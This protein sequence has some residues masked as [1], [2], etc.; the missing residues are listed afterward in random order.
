MADVDYIPH[1]Q[2]IKAEDL[3]ALVD[4]YNDKLKTLYSNLP[5][6]LIAQDVPT[7]MCFK[8]FFFC[9]DVNP[10]DDTIGNVALAAYPD[11]DTSGGVT[12]Y[13]KRAYIDS[14]FLSFAATSV[15]DDGD[16]DYEDV[17]APV[18]RV[19][20]YDSTDW[21]TAKAAIWPDNPSNAEAAYNIL[22]YSLTPHQKSGGDYDGDYLY[23]KGCA[24]SEYAHYWE[25]VEIILGSGTAS[26]FEWSIGFTKYRLFRFSNIT[27]EDIVV[28]FPV[29]DEEGDFVE[30]DEVTVYAMTS[31]CVRRVDT[32]P[33]QNWITGYEYFQLPL[34]DDPWF[35]NDQLNNALASPSQLPVGLYDGQV[36][37]AQSG[38]SPDNPFMRFSASGLWDLT[39][40]YCGTPT[41]SAGGSKHFPTPAGGW[42]YALD[43]ESSLMDYVLHKGKCLAVNVAGPFLVKRVPAQSATVTATNPTTITLTKFDDSIAL[44]VTSFTVTRDSDSTSI[45]ADSSGDVNWVLTN[46]DPSGPDDHWEVAFST[47]VGGNSPRLTAGDVLS[48]N[49]KHL[50]DDQKWLFDFK[51][52]DTLVEQMDTVGIT[53]TDPDPDHALQ[54]SL[55]SGDDLDLIGL[56]TNF[57][58]GSFG[59]AAVS[60]F[61]DADCSLPFINQLGIGIGIVNED[62]NP[63][64]SQYKTYTWSD[65]A[66]WTT[67]VFNADVG[68]SVDSTTYVY[69]SNTGF[70]FSLSD[71]V[72]DVFD[73]VDAYD[74]GVNSVGSSFRFTVFGA[75]FHWTSS[76][77]LTYPFAGASGKFFTTH[78]STIVGDGDTTPYSIGFENDD[79][80]GEKLSPSVPLQW[81]QP[82]TPISQ[83]PR[84]RR[85]SSNIRTHE[86]AVNVMQQ[87]QPTVQRPNVQAYYEPEVWQDGQTLKENGS[88]N[89][90]G[91]MVAKSIAQ[92]GAWVYTTLSAVWLRLSAWVNFSLI[93][94]M[95][96]DGTTGTDDFTAGSSEQSGYYGAERSFL[97]AGVNGGTSDAALGWNSIPFD[98]EQYNTLASIVNGLQYKNGGDYRSDAQYLFLEFNVVSGHL[99]RGLGTNGYR[100]RTQWISWDDS[101][102]FD[103]GGAGSFTTHMTGL[104]FTVLDSSDFPAPWNDFVTD[105]ITWYNP[106]TVTTDY[107]T[108]TTPIS[109]LWFPYHG[110]STEDVRTDAGHGYRWIAID[111]A[112]DVFDIYGARF[113]M[114]E[115]S[116]PATLEV[117]VGTPSLILAGDGLHTIPSTGGPCVL[118]VAHWW[119]DEEGDWV[120]TPENDVIRDDINPTDLSV[121]AASQDGPGSVNYGIYSIG[122]PDYLRS[123]LYFVSGMPVN[124][125]AAEVYNSV[126]LYRRFGCQGAKAIV[127][128]RN[129]NAYDVDYSSDGANALSRLKLST[130]LFQYNHL[131]EVDSLEG[132]SP[133]VTTLS[134]DENIIT[135]QIVNGQLY[136]FTTGTPL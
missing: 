108:G 91:Q 78:D 19:L 123:R 40:Y 130:G 48:L 2:E 99:S 89:A 3:A 117:N 57:V 56:S 12:R 26:P 101:E 6:F 18:V 92:V 84:V 29:A 34:P 76:V 75:A 86:A 116:C 114:Q 93:T 5:I 4:G 73:A 13:W 104:G 23:V 50:T 135:T 126:F 65:H 20:P 16:P 77:P 45:P 131:T 54:I 37:S 15:V 27:T 95:K 43:D 55:S 105:D 8:K 109:D 69:S 96:S 70:D 100:P 22:E 129:Y 74:F 38:G 1:G 42:F 120:Y 62:T 7:L 103:G 128:P 85:L 98:V 28:R 112:R 53:V 83:Y 47:R 41:V 36:S 115:L 59:T 64:D 14:A 21:A 111:D 134:A 49:F 106:P 25:Q 11:S 110:I 9:D 30:W 80:L 87:S 132:D 113:I 107:G 17:D 102:S 82:L 66:D 88:V 58:T 81:P 97:L 133:E 60:V 61:E 67:M 90:G 122:T 52:Y 51:G 125:A 127:W 63:I 119:N 68:V 32:L 71:T 33:V 79:Y 31:R 136:I 118:T 44:G 46:I 124:P 10:A 35:I 121:I 24:N 72:A 94:Y 39:G